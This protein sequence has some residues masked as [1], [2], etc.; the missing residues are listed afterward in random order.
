MTST[1]RITLAQLLVPLFA[2]LVPIALM[3]VGGYFAT[4][5]VRPERQGR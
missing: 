1:D 3:V 2:T 4:R 5:S